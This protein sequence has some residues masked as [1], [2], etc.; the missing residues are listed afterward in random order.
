MKNQRQPGQIWETITGQL[1]TD[2]GEDVF[3]SWF[4]RVEVESLE[5][6][7]VLLSVPT[8]FLRTWITEHYLELL[9][10]HWS[11]ALGRP[12][13]VDMAVRV[14]RAR[15]AGNSNG[16]RAAV[17]AAERAISARQS[18]GAEG[19]RPKLATVDG[20]P[21][22]SDSGASS[23]LDPRLT[24]ETLCVGTSNRLA[25]TAARQVAAVEPGA[26]L[27]FNPF[28]IHSGVGLGKSHVLQA[29]AAEIRAINPARKVLYLTAENFMYKFVAALRSDTALKFKEQLRSIDVL[30]I[31]DMQFLQGKSLQDEFCHTLNSL[32]DSG[33]QVVVA[34]DRA[35]A[36][37]DGLNDRVRSRLA[38]GLVIEIGPL[39]RELRREI[40]MRRVEA[41][42]RHY[43]D[44]HVPEA[45][46]D[47][48]ADQVTTNGRDLDGAFNRLI[49]HNQFNGTPITMELAERTVR[50]LVKASE[51]RRVRIEEIQ[52]LV[53]KH[54][55]VTK[56]DML[57]SRRNRSIVVPRQI[58]MYLSKVI[59]PRSLP[60][61]GRRFGG[62]DHTTVL[63]AVRKIEGLLARDNA[64]AQDIELLKR[65]LQE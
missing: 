62:R 49:A 61:I 15:V 22:T 48:I 20:A 5:G 13:A 51:P 9:A 30:L 18:A 56:A 8:K 54:Y 17:I 1:R 55:N 53:A 38:G 32:I 33:R 34:A 45:V 52:R 2:L 43:V 19:V 28:M 12:V 7:Q 60:E 26:P 4:A 29:I 42:R 11:R 59:T 37:L 31:D 6:D 63:H 39:E 65:Q 50:G 46:I 44:F 64:L 24:F 3:S 41:T 47:L 16:G 10:K 36:E 40:L 14:P 23:P 25:Y 58:A 21:V 35:P 27:L 57:S